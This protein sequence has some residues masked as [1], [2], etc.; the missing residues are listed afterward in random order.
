[1]TLTPIM[2]VV[3]IQVLDFDDA[4]RFLSIN[5]AI[6]A[7]GPGQ[8]DGGSYIADNPGTNNSPRQLNGYTDA[9]RYD[10]MPV[11]DIGGV[12]QTDF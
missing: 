10:L 8:L 7:S 2:K 6:S 11:V 4:G 3:V 5:P 1:M 12:V 9:F